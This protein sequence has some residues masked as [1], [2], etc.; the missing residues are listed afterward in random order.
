MVSFQPS[1]QVQDDL[2]TLF[3]RNLTFNPEVQSPAPLKVEEELKQQ[4]PDPAPAN[5]APAPIIYS[6]SQ[7]YTPNAHIVRQQQ[8]E[9]QHEVQRPS[10]EPPQTEQITPELVLA[11]HG[12]DTS[13]LSPAQF[14]LFRI[15]EEP[16]QL[17]LIELWRE[18]PPTSSND[19]PTLAWT[20]TTLEQEEQ[21]ARMRY[22]R[23][24]AE[25]QQQQQ[26]Q[27]QVMSLDGTQIQADDSRWL[28]SSISHHV[29]PYMMSGYEEM[30]RREQ[31]REQRAREQQAQEQRER[32][33]AELLRSSGNNYSHYG[34]AVGSSYKPATDPVYKGFGD[35]WAREQQMQME[36]QYGAYQ[37]WGGNMEAM[38]I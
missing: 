22:E 13:V 5:A 32:E 25:R 21:L 26:Q 33:Q 8:Q 34:S 18:A 4:S 24:E 29:E 10:S 31:E 12:V 36:N 14:Q 6:I 27:Q 16:H 7:H 15:S 28:A 11:Q 35:D 3:S 23:M 2:A 20:S 19:N 38:E 1:M 17:R 9:P 37:A 30:M